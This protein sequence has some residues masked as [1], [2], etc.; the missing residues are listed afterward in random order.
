MLNLESKQKRTIWSINVILAVSQA[1][2]EM[3]S[4]GVTG[5]VRGFESQREGKEKPGHMQSTH[6]VRKIELRISAENCTI[7]SSL[8]HPVQ[9]V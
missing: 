9:K 2:I 3:R 5:R 6:P 7:I 8:I 4:D 1:K